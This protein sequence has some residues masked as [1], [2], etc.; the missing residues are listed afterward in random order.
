MSRGDFI[1]ADVKESRNRGLEKCP[2]G[3][4]YSLKMKSCPNCGRPNP[5]HLRKSSGRP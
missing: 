4:T 5:Y 3:A 1:R 2:C